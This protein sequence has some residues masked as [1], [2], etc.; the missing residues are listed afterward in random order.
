[1][2]VK[3]FN[4]VLEDFH[5][6]LQDAQHCTTTVSLCEDTVPGSTSG[7]SEDTV[8]GS[9]SGSEDTV[10]GSTRG[11]SEDTVPGSTSGASDINTQFSRR[12][13]SEV[14]KTLLTDWDK[15]GKA[16]CRSEAVSN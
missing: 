15:R 4:R 1:M 10:P 6:Y 16:D 11:A 8:P 14:S 2:S 7:A 9:T 3:S 12:R 13:Q 5:L